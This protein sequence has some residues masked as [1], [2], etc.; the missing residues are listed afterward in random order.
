MRSVFLAAALAAFA[1]LAVPLVRAQDA[2]LADTVVVTADRAANDARR[3]GRRVTVITAD[4]IARAP[5]AS[6]D[7]LLRTAAGVDVLSRGA[8]G[9]Q[10]DVTIR[11]ASFQG[12]LLLVDGV[13]FNDPMTAHFLSDFPVPVGE[14]ARVEILRGPAAALYGPDA[15]G[16]VVHVLTWTG[17]A[18]R[19]GSLGASARVERGSHGYDRS[20]IAVRIPF[21]QTLLGFAAEGAEADGEAVPGL[22][23]RPIVRRAGGAETPIRAGFDRDAFTVAAARRIGGARLTARF[24]RDRRAFDAVRFYT[25]FRSD[26]AREATRTLWAQAALASRETARTAWSVSAGGRE[27]EDV[28]DFNGPTASNTHTSRQATLLATVQRRLR[29]GVTVGVGASA[30]GRSIDSNNLGEH[31]D[32]AAGAYAQA[33]YN[34]ASGLSASASARVDYDDGFGTEVT[35]QFAV[36]FTR[37]RAGLR[38]SAGRAVRAPSFIE[39]Y[40]NTTLARPRG[41]DLGNRSLRAERAWSAEAGADAELAPGVGVHFTLF[42]RETEGL[43]DFV[44]APADTVFRAQNLLDASARGVEAEADAVFGRVRARLAYTYLDLSVRGLPVGAVGKY[45]LANA[46]HS[47]QASA[48][49]RVGPATVALESLLRDPYDDAGANDPDPARDGPR[50][51]RPYA[52]HNVRVSAP[53]PFRRL[54]LQLTAE[55][56]NVTDA[57]FTEVFAPLPGRWFVFGVAFE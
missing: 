9:V 47:I 22:D 29:A 6:L 52:V 13:R 23:G 18:A 39:R 15:L 35:P 45:V 20:A 48:S 53:I 28:Y 38:A 12:V 44:L 19:D 27:H 37:A 33:R 24:A 10:S 32:G 57:R 31:A 26:T 5:A 36:A 51:D 11:G 42:Q 17:L 43:I 14:I 21:G 25:P 3:T 50:T 46:R 55:V 56:R 7:E 41:R 34:G 8:F 1:V 16:G 4:D 30:L 2:A 49:A 40:L 54:P